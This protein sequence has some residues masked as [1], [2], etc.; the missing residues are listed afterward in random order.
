MNCGMNK[1]KCELCG[2][3]VKLLTSARLQGKRLCLA[4]YTREIERFR[5][6]LVVTYDEDRETVSSILQRAHKEAPEGYTLLTVRRARNSRHTWE[7]EY[8]K[9]ELFESRCS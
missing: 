9:T 5:K 3:E 2:S 6:N 8:E 1:V 7:A 4:D